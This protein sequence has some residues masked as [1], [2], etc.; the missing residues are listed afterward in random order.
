MRIHT[1]RY[2]SHINGY[3]G[4]IFSLD[5]LYF[6]YAC[7]NIILH[8]KYVSLQETRHNKPNVNTPE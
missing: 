6:P 8:V 4:Y 7:H 1:N 5:D 3:S 2:K